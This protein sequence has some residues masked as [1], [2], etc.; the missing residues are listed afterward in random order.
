MFF[1][2]MQFNLFRA[3]V[4]VI[5]LMEFLLLRFDQK[6]LYLIGNYVPF[7]MPMIETI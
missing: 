4:P 7:P 3:L 2:P 6:G 5:F 1:K